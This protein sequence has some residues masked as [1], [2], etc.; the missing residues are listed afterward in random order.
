MSASAQ[1]PTLIAVAHGSRRPTAQLEVRQLLRAMRAARPGLEVREAYIELAQPLLPDVLRSVPGA[2]VVVPLLLGNGYHI[3]HDVAGVTAA[4][5]PG[6]MCAAALGP[7]ALLVEALAQRLHAAEGDM[8]SDR[9]VLAAAGSSD[10]RAQADA[11]RSAR[12]LAARIG[13][14]VVPA[15]N[16][17]TRP[18]VVETVAALRRAGHRRIGVASYLLWPGRFAA[19][20]AACGADVVTAPIGAHP[21]LVDLVLRRYDAALSRSVIPVG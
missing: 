15:Y 3:A 6:T 16:T 20:V 21:A 4:H 5:R 1:T 2:A 7:D 12:L 17:A 11:E 13:R 8:P 9:V 19:E 14:E 18:A 10:R